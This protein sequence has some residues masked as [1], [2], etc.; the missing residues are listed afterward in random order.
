MAPGAGRADA[1]EVELTP[2]DCNVST[3]VDVC[4]MST[5]RHCRQEIREIF[6][7]VWV[8]DHDEPYCEPDGFQVHEPCSAIVMYV[9]PRR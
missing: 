3:W 5:C 1:G 4:A 9:R 2:D 7:L 6:A 8:D